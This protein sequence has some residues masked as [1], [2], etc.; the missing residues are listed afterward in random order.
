M[1]A[2]PDDQTVTV[3]LVAHGSRASSANQA[4][5]DLAAALAARIEPTVLGAFME[6]AEP[7]I[8]DAIGR[9]VDAGATVVAVLPYFLH[10]GRHQQVDIPQLVAEAAET[11][12]GVEVRLLDPFGA[13]PAVLDLLAGQVS[14]AVDPT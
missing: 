13:D 11:R 7:S 2:S 9:A 12:S 8:G 3:V 14:R 4:H 5:L 1:V 10:P 6:L